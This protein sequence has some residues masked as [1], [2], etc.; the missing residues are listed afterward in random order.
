MITVSCTSDLAKKWAGFPLS[1]ENDAAQLA[2]QLEKNP[3]EWAAAA[4]FL[5]RTDLDTLALGRYELTPGGT[6]ANIQEYETKP[7]NRYE[8]HKAYADV[9]VVL[10]GKEHI[11]IAPIGEAS[12]RLTDFD[13]KKDIEF[14]ASAAAGEHV[15]LAD[16]GHWVVLFPSDLHKPCLT[17]GEEPVHIR[18]IVVKVKL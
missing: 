3:A 14:F 8:A 12:E 2:E 9:Q 4:E 18:K 5:S 15:A 10:A 6:F 7:E 16:R 1:E 11:V 17:I 13:E